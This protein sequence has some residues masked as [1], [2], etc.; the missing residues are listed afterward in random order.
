VPGAA[1]DGLR[2]ERKDIGAAEIDADIRF[3]VYVRGT[4]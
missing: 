2:L 1:V 3:A 4:P